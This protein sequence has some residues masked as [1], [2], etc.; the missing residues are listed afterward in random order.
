MK[1]WVTGSG[2]LIGNALCQEASRAVPEWSVI[3]LR[4]ESLDLSH[5]EAVSRAFERDLP[6]A[7]IHC[8]ALARSGDCERDPERARLINVGVTR[9]LATLCADRPFVLLSS[10]LVFDG[11][12]G[13]YTEED[14][15]S[16]ITVY[17]RTK[18]EAEACVLR[19]PRHL[20]VRTSLNCG[21]SPTGDRAFNEEWLRAWREGQVLRLFKD[22]FRCPIPATETARCLWELLRLACTG[23][24]HLA[25][26]ERLSRYEMGLLLAARYPE[27]NPRFEAVCLRTFQGPPRSPDT[28]LLCAKAY[29]V[30]S[31]PPMPFSQWVRTHTPT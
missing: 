20:V 11:R 28:S 23:L 10:D 4:H 17:G 24:Y 15:V 16:P 19:N 25:G 29:R 8:A 6:D 26:P 21:F 30:L 5:F 9:H 7:V 3:G 13:A 27:L 14:P 18:A 12:K 1:I 31:Q 22:E 2:G